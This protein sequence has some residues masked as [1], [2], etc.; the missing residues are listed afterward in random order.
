VSVL[1]RIRDRPA[2]HSVDRGEHWRWG[3]RLAT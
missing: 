2:H 1:Q 3:Q